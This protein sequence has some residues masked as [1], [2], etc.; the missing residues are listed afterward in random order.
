M[1]L[2]VDD[3]VHTTAIKRIEH[4]ADEL[5]DQHVWP[6]IKGIRDVQV[7][8][9]DPK[10]EVEDPTELDCSAFIKNMSSQLNGFMFKHLLPIHITGGYRE[11][12]EMYTDDAYSS[13]KAFLTEF[14][15]YLTAKIRAILID[16]EKRTK[17]N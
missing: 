13:C 1:T 6:E 14:D 12:V 2:D 11:A 7:D 9:V 17:D 5:I 8:K 10:T 3:S 16:H 15:N 4:H